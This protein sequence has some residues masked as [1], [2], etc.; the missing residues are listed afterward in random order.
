M[1]MEIQLGLIYRRLCSSS[2]FTWAPLCLIGFIMWLTWQIYPLPSRHSFEQRQTTNRPKVTPSL[3]PHCQQWAAISEEVSIFSTEAL[4][5]QSP[6]H[7]WLSIRPKLHSPERFVILL[8]ILPLLSMLSMHI[9]LLIFDMQ[10]IVSARKGQL[11]QNTKMVSLTSVML[12]GKK[13]C[14]VAYFLVMVRVIGIFMFPKSFWN[15]MF[16]LP[17]Y[18]RHHVHVQYCFV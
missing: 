12:Q 11:S 7:L 2:H 17:Y 9:M 6:L 13:R 5:P 16:R 3:K 10:S 1:D 4:C 18:G 15:L 14:I 8:Y